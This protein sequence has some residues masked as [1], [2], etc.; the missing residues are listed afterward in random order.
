[1]VPALAE[2]GVTNH[3]L[4]LFAW[5]TNQA[6]AKLGVYLTAAAYGLWSIEL[7]TCGRRDLQLLGAAG[8]V[9]GLGPALLLASGLIDMRVAGA[10]A[11]YAAHAFWAA[12]VGAMLFR[13]SLAATS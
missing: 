6:F 4:F 7:L 8:I 5:F 12:L 3:D 2:R 10:F 13:G 9:A 11:I 1:V